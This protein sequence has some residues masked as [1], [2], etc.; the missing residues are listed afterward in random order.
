MFIAQLSRVSHFILFLPS[1]PSLLS[2]LQILHPPVSL[3]SPEAVTIIS[4]A[5]NM[6]DTKCK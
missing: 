1:Y 6:K 5:P 2:P 3:W 4:G